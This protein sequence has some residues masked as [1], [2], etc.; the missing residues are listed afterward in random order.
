[1]VSGRE[2]GLRRNRAQGQNSD[3]NRNAFVLPVVL[4]IFV[5]VL[6]V[7]LTMVRRSRDARGTGKPNIAVAVALGI[8][9]AV[10]VIVITN[11]LGVG[12]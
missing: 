1:M 12:R 3:V 4:T 7:V 8:G 10:I 6:G 9:G 2:S 5:V 11:A